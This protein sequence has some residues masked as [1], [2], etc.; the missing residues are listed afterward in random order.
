MF[1]SHSLSVRHI[2]VTTVNHYRLR[3]KQEQGL[4]V[5]ELLL[6]V[7]VVLL[8]VGGAVVALRSQQPPSTTSETQLQPIGTPQ[9]P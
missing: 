7:V 3:S 6:I 1:R 8:A 4:T 9:Q 2:P 5:G